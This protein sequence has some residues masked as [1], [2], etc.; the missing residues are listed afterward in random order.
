MNKNTFDRTYGSNLDDM[1]LVTF[2]ASLTRT[3]VALADNAIV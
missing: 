1:L 3:Q 2:L